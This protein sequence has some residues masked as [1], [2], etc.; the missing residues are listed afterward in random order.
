MRR[1]IAARPPRVSTRVAFSAIRGAGP[2]TLGACCTGRVADGVGLYH[3]IAIQ[4]RSAS[5]IETCARCNESL[6]AMIAGV[7]RED[8]ESGSRSSTSSRKLGIPRR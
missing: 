4:Q 2:L 7:G 6:A 5:R 1:L 3:A 8:I